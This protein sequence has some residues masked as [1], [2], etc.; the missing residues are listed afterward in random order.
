MP[1]LKYE[2]INGDTADIDYYEDVSQVDEE[3]YN[4]NLRE[5]E[6]INEDEKQAEPPPKDS[7]AG[8]TI[9]INIQDS[10]KES[11]KRESES[12]KG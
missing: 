2:L 11:S 9:N 5:T 1:K 8:N 3:E 12:D 7:S 6:Y 4:N 10:K